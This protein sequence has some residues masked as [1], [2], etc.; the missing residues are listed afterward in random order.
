MEVG[1]I[2]NLNAKKNRKKNLNS[3]ILQPVIEGL[4]EVRDTRTFEEMEVALEEFKKRGV[5]ILGVSGGDGT[6]QRV[7]TAWIRKFGE[8]SLPKILLL[9][10]GATDA[11]IHAIG[12]KLK[13]PR[14]T[15]KDFV[16]E[17]SQKSII[18]KKMKLLKVEIDD[19][20]EYGVSFANGI[21]YKLEKKYED[22]G[23]PGVWGVFVE[24]LQII[25]GIIFRVK[26]YLDF[27]RISQCEVYV[28]SRKLVDGILAVGVSVL[29]RPFPVVNPFGGLKRRV[30]EVHYIVAKL[31][32]WEAL[33]NLIK[34]AFGKL[35]ELHTRKGGFFERGTAEEVILRTADGF[36]IDGE[37][38]ELSEVKNIKISSGPEVEFIVV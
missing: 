17:V 27:I 29:D 30:D 35:N 36:I 12:Q 24:I 6:A 7:I 11:V 8:E 16:E 3:K 31:N 19:A 32:F 23:K 20:V 9:A 22:D 2:N 28:S 21:I 10:G 25:F 37:I 26:K 13:C 15:L 34:I 1:I 18:V 5:K 4:G 38:F 33:K 14:Q